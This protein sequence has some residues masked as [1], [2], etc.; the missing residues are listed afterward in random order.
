MSQLLQLWPSHWPTNL[1]GFQTNT[2]MSSMLWTRSRGSNSP[3]R[4]PLPPPKVEDVISPPPPPPE[5]EEEEEDPPM[6]LL[7]RSDLLSP[8][9]RRAT[10][11]REQRKIICRVLFFQA[12]FLSGCRE[13]LVDERKKHLVSS[14]E[15]AHHRVYV[16]RFG[17][18]GGYPGHA[19]VHATDGLQH[20]AFVLAAAARHQLR[21]VYKRAGVRIAHTLWRA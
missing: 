12:R 7:G 19:P 21:H 18:R 15:S 10:L 11:S 16:A 20:E 13:R 2:D 8:A 6:A 14:S 3:P 17:R 9:M 4:E 5:E 1:G